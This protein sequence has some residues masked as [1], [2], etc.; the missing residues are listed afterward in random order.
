MSKAWS[1][2]WRAALDNDP[3]MFPPKP[4]DLNE[5]QYA[6]LICDRFCDVGMFSFFNFS[7]SSSA[8]TCLVEDMSIMF[9]WCF[10][11]RLCAV[12]F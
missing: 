8:Q 2:V 7:P 3:D 12:R 10:R 4:D 1:A 5:P 9:Y 6:S 11:R